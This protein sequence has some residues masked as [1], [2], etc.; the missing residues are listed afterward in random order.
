MSKLFDFSATP[1]QVNIIRSGFRYWRK[2][3]LRPLPAFVWSD[4][5]LGSPFFRFLLLPPLPEEALF[6]SSLSL[7]SRDVLNRV[8]VVALLEPFEELALLGLEE[9]EADACF[10]ELFIIPPVEE[11][12]VE[13][14]SGSVFFDVDV[15][16]RVDPIQPYGSAADHGGFIRRSPN[17]RTTGGVAGKEEKNRLL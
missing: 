3:L 2:S 6:T 7:C 12:V 10:C 1:L 15:N 16:V 9:V 13:D 8:V 4:V 14:F 17:C 11:E 5:I